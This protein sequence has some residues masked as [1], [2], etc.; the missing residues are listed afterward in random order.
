MQKVKKKFA[1]SENVTTFAPVNPKRLIQALRK[2]DMVD[3]VRVPSAPQKKPE[4]ATKYAL[5]AFFVVYPLPQRP[6]PLFKPVLM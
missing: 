6:K 2:R 4:E 1:G 5:R 3:G